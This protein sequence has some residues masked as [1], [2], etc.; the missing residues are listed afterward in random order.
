MKKSAIAIAVLVLVAAG[1]VLPAGYFGQVTETTLRERMANMPYGFQMELTDYRRGWFSSTA[2]LEWDPLGGLPMPGL[3]PQGA[4]PGADA[5]DLPA[6]VENLVSGP[7]AIDIEIAHGPVFFAVGPGAG[8]FHARGRVDLGAAASAGDEESANGDLELYV[9][10][11]SGATVDNRLEVADAEWD[12]GTMALKLEGA[13]L[14]GEWT[15]PE[16]FQLQRAELGNMNMSVGVAGTG[17]RF[18]MSDLESSTEF[19]QGLESGAILAPSQSTSSVGEILVEQSDGNAVLRMSG[20]KSEETAAPEEDGTYRVD[21]DITIE[22]MEVLNREF[23]PI[24]VR[25]TA[26]GFSEDSLLQL[27]TALGDGI[28]D[29]SAAPQAPE[30]GPQEPSATPPAG[31][32]AGPPAAATPP[33]SRAMQEAIV[34]FLADGPY[35]DMNAVLTYQGE[36]TL[37]L[38]LS[39]AFDKEFA[40]AT[41]EQ[42]NLLGILSGLDYT[43]D[44]EIPI[45]AAEELFGQGIIQLGLMQGLLQPTETTYTVSLALADGMLN[46]NGRPMPIPL[47]PPT[48]V[49]GVAP[50][51]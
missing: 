50:P 46:I 32:P 25:Q 45:A 42:V 14:E 3:G 21:S 20:M 34:A 1:I 48:A 8:L 7:I 10:S 35:T 37:R 39:Y 12:L 22:S 43:L 5:M 30:D 51:G 9:S 49:P 13:L 44:A 16:S 6:G 47:G 2:R 19:P 15:G 38:D 18:A 27:L 40:P 26:G 11:F 24:E 29:A 23:A 41:L 17:L 28:F 33:L 36:H 31:P 4:L